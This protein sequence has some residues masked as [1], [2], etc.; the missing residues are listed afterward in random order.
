VFSQAEMFSIL[1]QLSKAEPDD[2]LSL[3][4]QPK[5]ALVERGTSGTLNPVV[6]WHVVARPGASGDGRGDQQEIPYAAFDDACMN[7]PAR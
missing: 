3:N 4:I 5:E 6:G 2:G 7:R 1:A